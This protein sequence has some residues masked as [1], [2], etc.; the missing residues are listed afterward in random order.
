[1][2]FLKLVSGK[3][4]YFCQPLA[5][6]LTPEFLQI[7]RVTF[8]INLWHDHIFGHIIASIILRLIVAHSSPLVLPNISN[9]HILFLR[10]LSDMSN[11][12]LFESISLS[13]L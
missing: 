13:F 5:I 8:T 1:M 12:L 2:P 7:I 4:S 9:I 10:E 3:I 11:T 6:S